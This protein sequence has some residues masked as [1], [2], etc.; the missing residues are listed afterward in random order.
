VRVVTKPGLCSK[1]DWYV[2]TLQEKQK[3][4]MQTEDNAA[5]HVGQTANQNIVQ[6]QFGS[7]CPYY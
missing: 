5:L 2:R 3:L 1:V 4:K 6:V 7:N